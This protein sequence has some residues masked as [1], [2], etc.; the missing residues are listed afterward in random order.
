MKLLPI[1]SQNWSEILIDFV[2]DLPENEKCY[3]LLLIIDKFGKRVILKFYNSMD[4]EA[5]TEIFIRRFYR[6]HGL[7]AI[8]MSDRGR[9]FVNILWKKICKIF[10]IERKFS[11]VYHLQID[12]ATERMN[13]TVETFLRVYIDFDQR[14]WVKFLSITEFVINNKN[15]VTT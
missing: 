13:Q 14:N 1:P 15:A 6:Q 8:L 11:T 4:A 9:Q 10:G 7:F 5:A 3:F 2:I 12:G